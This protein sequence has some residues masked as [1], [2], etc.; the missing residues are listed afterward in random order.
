MTEEV[1]GTSTIHLGR[2]MKN[3]QCTWTHCWSNHGAGLFSVM[4]ILETSCLIHFTFSVLFCLSNMLKEW[5]APESSL[6]EKHT[7][8]GYISIQKQKNTIIILG[9]IFLIVPHNSPAA[10]IRLNRLGEAIPTD[11]DNMWFHGE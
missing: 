7:H 1:I 4:T 10:G 5:H 9:V 2:P 8:D 6:S 11:T 3:Q